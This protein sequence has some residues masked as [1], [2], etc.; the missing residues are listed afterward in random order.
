LR[1]GSGHTKAPL[2]SAPKQ[3]AT[4]K[5]EAPGNFPQ[6]QDWF[7]AG[8]LMSEKGLNL[9]NH[10][11]MQENIA[12]YLAHRPEGEALPT[13][14]WETKLERELSEPYTDNQVFQHVDS[15][16]A[17]LLDN[18]SELPSYPKEVFIT[19][20]FSK[21]RLGANSDMNGYAVLP[22]DEFQPAFENFQTRFDADKTSK[23]ANLFPMS[24][25]SPGFNK[26]MFLVEGTSVK[27]STDRL[28]EQGYLRSVYTDLLDTKNPERTESKPGSDGIVGKMWR[29]KFE[30]QTFHFRA[31]R[32]ALH[33]GG[34][35]SRI[36]LLGSAL[37]AGV[38]RVV[39]QDHRDLT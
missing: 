5:S 10:R 32:W 8:S 38:E 7:D 2:L 1:I 35:L 21:A 22:S 15:L 3:R 28:Q 26:G 4:E 19:G 27:L 25:S 23:N 31:M 29:S 14:R 33:L 6:N 39:R 36:P 30:R 34:T 18:L 24:E 9:Q 12:T 17:S 20:S 13:G 16:Q 37:E 11:L